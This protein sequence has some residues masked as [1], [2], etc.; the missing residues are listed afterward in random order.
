MKKLIILTDTYLPRFDGVSRFLREVLPGIKNFDIE[1]ICPDYRY[2]KPFD[3]DYKVTLFK[4]V[5]YS[6]S[7][8]SPAFPKL[9]ILK[10][11]IKSADL[12]FSQTMGPIGIMGSY[13]AKKFDK[14]LISFVHSV[15]WELF[16]NSINLPKWLR[17]TAMKISKLVPRWIYN[18]NDLILVPSTETEKSLIRQKI[19]APKRIL[20][21]GTNVEKFKPADKSEAKK[22]A[23]F[24]E[25]DLVVG[26][27][28]RISYEKDLPVLYKAF[29][30]IKSAYPDK[31]IKLLIVGDGED[32]IK[33]EMPD[34]KITGFVLDV[35]PY[36]QAM[37]VFVL[38]SLTE[39]SSLSTMEA[40]SAG[41]PVITTRVGFLNTYIIERVN[42][43][44]INSG[45]VNDLISKLKLLIED[46]AMREMLGKNARQTIITSYTWD[47]TI[48]KLNRI[49][50]TILE[51]IHEN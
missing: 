18:K 33:K 6:V 17:P 36:L 49:L 24:E 30:T 16:A 21:L 3:Y 50:N 4:P 31:N 43:L 9:K 11:R 12:V 34:A 39:T 45:D 28:G 42:G 22:K 32:A 37:D 26:Y 29:K 13:Y 19:T 20:H 40:M 8:Y 27:V 46:T 10:E 5:K 47:A 1:I 38:T 7:D 44:N 48:E 41:L 14:T 35:V 23:G 15:D 25:D 51:N 2:S